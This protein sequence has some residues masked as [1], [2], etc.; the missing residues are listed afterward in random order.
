MQKPTGHERASWAVYT[1]CF[2]YCAI[3]QIYSVAA[4]ELHHHRPDKVIASGKYALLH[5]AMQKTL[6][7]ISEILNKRWQTLLTIFRRRMG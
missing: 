6:F 7:S 5:M 2:E 3:H 1:Q 4:K